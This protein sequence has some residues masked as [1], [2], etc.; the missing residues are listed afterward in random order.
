M[1][2]K[3]ALKV[4]KTP[5]PDAALAARQIRPSKRL[6]RQIF[7]TTDP[8]HQMAVLLP[9][10]QATSVEVRVDNVTDDPNAMAQAGAGSCMG[11]DGR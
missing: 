11:G 9:G 8:K 10:S 7:G 6:L 4:T 2:C 3:L 1:S 5:T